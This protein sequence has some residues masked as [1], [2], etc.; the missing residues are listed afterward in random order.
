MKHASNSD[1]VVPITDLEITT[2][3]HAMGPLKCPGVDGLQADKNLP[4]RAY[5]SHTGLDINPECL[6]CHFHDETFDHLLVDCPLTTQAPSF[7][8]HKLICDGAPTLN[9]SFAGAGGITRDNVGLFV[10]GFSHHL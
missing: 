10:A 3:L 9:S 7:P 6:L 2:A 1:L 5:L 4:V 8:L